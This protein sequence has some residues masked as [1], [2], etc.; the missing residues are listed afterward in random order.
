MSYFTSNS[1]KIY[2][3]LTAGIFGYKVLVLLQ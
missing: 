3:V 2:E 1:L